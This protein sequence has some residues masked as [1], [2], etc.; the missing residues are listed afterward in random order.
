MKKSVWARWMRLAHRA[1]EIQ[2]HVLFFLLYVLAM[3]PLG[4][5]HPAGRRALTHKTSGRPAWRARESHPTDLAASRR[6][7]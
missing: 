5:L 3:V 2:A 4:L 6:Q 1:A 7:F